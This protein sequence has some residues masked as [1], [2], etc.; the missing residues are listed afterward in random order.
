MLPDRLRQPSEF[1]ADDGEVGGVGGDGLLLRQQFLQL[2]D[3]DDELIQRRTFRKSVVR[4]P[5]CDEVVVLGVE[6]LGSNHLPE[7]DGHGRDAVGLSEELVL[8]GRLCAPDGTADD[9][10]WFHLAQTLD[11]LLAVEPGATV[12]L[13]GLR[14]DVGDEVGLLD[15]DRI[16]VEV[17][18]WDHVASV[19][20]GSIGRGRGGLALA[21][22]D[23]VNV[24]RRRAREATTVFLG[25][26]V[27]ADGALAGAVYPVNETTVLP[28]GDLRLALDLGLPVRGDPRRIAVSGSVN[29]NFTV[30]VASRTRRQLFGAPS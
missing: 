28:L 18:G 15:G 14:K 24:E 13:V 16:K 30:S 21:I 5:P 1:L 8:V 27:E 26:V 7:S 25:N 19:M 12:E 22:N 29:T 3:R 9:V 17:V 20:S 6:G 4:E 23:R 11:D 10:Q 2:A